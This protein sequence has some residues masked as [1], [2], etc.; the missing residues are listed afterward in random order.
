MC[1]VVV[2][3]TYHDVVRS[4]SIYLQI[5]QFPLLL[6]KYCYLLENLAFCG[7]MKI[8]NHTFFNKKGDK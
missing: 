8:T 2:K 6:K 1:K 3:K 5:K 7:I 4:R